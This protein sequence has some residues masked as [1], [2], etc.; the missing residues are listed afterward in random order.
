[1]K[2]ARMKYVTSQ[3]GILFCHVVTQQF[4]LSLLDTSGNA[5]RRRTTSTTTVLST[6]R[7]TPQEIRVPRVVR[8]TTRSRASSRRTTTRS[9]EQYQVTCQS[10][11]PSQQ[12]N[13]LCPLKQ[14]VMKWP[15]I[16]RMLNCENVRCRIRSESRSKAAP[17]HTLCP[18]TGQQMNLMVRRLNHS[19]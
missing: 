13:N 19:F 7:H 17:S 10:R 1:M 18:C 5:E 4:R 3:T 14:A 6:H 16:S 11:K 15:T 8:R 12:S 2:A 9:C